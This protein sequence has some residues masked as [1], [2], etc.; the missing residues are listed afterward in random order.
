MTDSRAEEILRRQ[1]ALASERA[2]FD[3]LWQEAAEYVLPRQA[4]FTRQRSPGE[5]QG[6]QVFDDTAPFALERFA[7]AIQ[8]VATPPTDRWHTLMLDLPEEMLEPGTP[9]M[10]WLEAVTARLFRARYA[11]QAN[12]INQSLEA[13][14]SLGAFGTGALYLEE[15]P[16]RGL[17]YQARH[18]KEFYLA[19]D[20]V[21]RIDTVHRAFELTARQAKQRWGEMLPGAILRCVDREPDKKFPFVHCVKPGVESDSNWP[22]ASYYVSVEGKALLSVG[23]Y[24]TMPYAIGRYVQ[25]PGEVYGRGPGVQG[26]RTLRVLNQMIVTMMMTAEKVADPPL[27]THDDDVLQAFMT[28]PGYINRGGVSSEGRPLVQP[29]QI[30]ANLPVTMEIIQQYREIVNSAF[31]VTLF[32]ILVE[33]RTQMTATEVLYR[34]QEKGAL[35]APAMGRLQSEFLGPL[36]ERELDILAEARQLPEPPAE[37]LQYLPQSED[38]GQIVFSAAFRPEYDSPFTRMQR[39]QEGVGILRTLESVT[40]LAQI[41]PAVLDIFDTDEIVKVLAKVNGLPSKVL[42]NAEDVKETRNV[43]DQ[44]AKAKALLEAA[45]VG[46]KAA[47]NA[48]KAQQTLGQ[49]GQAPL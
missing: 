4:V 3:T 13:Y 12:F 41:N 26:L 49:A 20:A 11:P 21:G 15:A 30:G 32:Q 37:L 24:R 9:T 42:R 1:D 35:L 48:S 44:A 38:G 7:G 31:L 39:A 2:N 25:A 22:L 36:I 28:V 18:L 45:D 14:M 5:E 29:L 27:L 23:G 40:P 47:L 19:E 8:S 33:D 46:S 17:R 6:E 10:K 34:Q 16:G 43:R